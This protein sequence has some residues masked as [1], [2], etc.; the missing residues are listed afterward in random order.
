MP[1]GPQLEQAQLKDIP[2]I[3]SLALLME[4]TNRSHLQEHGFINLPGESKKTPTVFVKTTDGNI[5]Y[6][7]TVPAK[8][9]PFRD[10]TNNDNP[11]WIGLHIENEDKSITMSCTRN[12]RIRITGDPDQLDALLPMDPMDRAKLIPNNQSQLELPVSDIRSLS[13]VTQDNIKKIV[14]QATKSLS[15]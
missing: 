6:E 3:Q 12:G 4:N 5:H 14:D 9:R 13:P 7:S 11:D 10:I 15:L 1:D 8:R 2:L